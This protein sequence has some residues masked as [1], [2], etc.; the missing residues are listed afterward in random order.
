MAHNPVFAG[1][2]SDALTVIP[3]AVL[4]L[5]L[6]LAGREVILGSKKA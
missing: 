5:L 3:F 6:Y 4:C 1:D 2:Y